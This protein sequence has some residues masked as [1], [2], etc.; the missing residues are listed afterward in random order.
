[1]NEYPAEP[2]S[3][4]LPRP[5][6]GAGIAM[7]AFTILVSFYARVTGS[8][9]SGP[10]PGNIA[11]ERSLEFHDRSDGAVVVIASP[12]GDTVSV[13]A[14]GS[15]GFIRGALRAFVRERRMRQIGPETPFVLTRWDSGAI[16]LKD[17]A[18]GARIDLAAF[19]P[20]N[21]DAF[22]R[23]LATRT[24]AFAPARP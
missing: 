13:L 20:T 22:A 18:V 21:R 16:T 2:E 5:I 19:G 4:H 15:N 12:T 23:L 1:M 17:P 6:I 14:P 10:P 9:V 11:E 3:I 7:V 8:G 24:A